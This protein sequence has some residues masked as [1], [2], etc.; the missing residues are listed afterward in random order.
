MTPGQPREPLQQ[1]IYRELADGLTARLEGSGLS[2]EAYFAAQRRIQARAWL[3][4]G[5]CL[6]MP[7]TDPRLAEAL[8]VLADETPEQSAADKALMRPLA[9]GARD[10]GRHVR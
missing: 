5:R 3:T 7:D 6:E 9:S 1:R 10:R 8:T 4:I 2:W